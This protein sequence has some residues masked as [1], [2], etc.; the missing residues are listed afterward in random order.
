[1]EIATVHNSINA[2]SVL[3]TLY[4][5]SRVYRPI[6]EFDD[7]SSYIKPNERSCNLL[8]SG[9]EY[10]LTVSDVLSHCSGSIKLNSNTLP[11]WTQVNDITLN[12][13]LSSFKLQAT[14]ICGWYVVEII[15]TSEHGQDLSCV[16]TNLG[17]EEKT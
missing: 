9:V 16:I 3:F 8:R 2:L 4:E 10:R 6:R 13:G 7:Y 15:N 1:M 17:Y 14:W 12:S 11:L 5:F